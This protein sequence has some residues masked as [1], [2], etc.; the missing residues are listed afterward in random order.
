MRNLVITGI[1]TLLGLNGVAAQAC[2]AG[3]AQEINGNWYCSAVKAI[4]YTNFPGTGAYNKVIGMNAANGECTT[5]RY[6]YSGS[7]S[8]LNEEVSVGNSR[9]PVTRETPRLT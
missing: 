5:E 7:L 3:T 2:A 1:G 4:S 6:S 8:P 9:A